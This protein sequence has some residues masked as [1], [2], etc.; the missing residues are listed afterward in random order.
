MDWQPIETAP[1]DMRAVLILAVTG[2]SSGD[3]YVTTG[4]YGATT[5]D[6]KAKKYR[7]G[8]KNTLHR[9]LDATHWMPLPPPPALAEGEQ[10]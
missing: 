1:K 8:W 3:S 5:Y 7:H 9:E 10:P 4:W 6:R 2:R